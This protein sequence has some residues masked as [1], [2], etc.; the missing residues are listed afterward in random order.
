MDDDI[1]G[2]AQPNARPGDVRVADVSGPDGVPDGKITPDDRIIIPRD[3]KWLGSFSSSFRFKGFELSADVYTVQGVTKSNQFLYEYNQGGRMD[4]VLN[5]VKR[6][7][8]TP[9][10]PSNNYFRPHNV[11]YSE[12]R[13]AVGYQDASY[14]RLKN[15]TLTY[16]LPQKWIKTVGLSMVRIYISG[17]NLI[18]KTKFLSYSPESEVD[19]YPE[20]RN[21]TLGLNINF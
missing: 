4:G 12:Y 13:D 9:E 7:Y 19:D 6:D 1:A 8:W 5:G 10:K 16:D 11:N 21:Y 18:T 20:T 14:V 17:D 2:S 15:V 3:P